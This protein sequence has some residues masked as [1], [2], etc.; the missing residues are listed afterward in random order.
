MSLPL[1]AAP[2]PPTLD[3]TAKPLRLQALA[4]ALAQALVRDRTPPS[5]AQALTPTP[6]EALAQA[7]VRDWTPPSAA[8]ALTPTPAVALAQA[9]V[10]DQIRPSAAQALTPTPAEALAQAL[11]AP[12]AARALAP[13][14]RGGR[15]VPWGAAWLLSDVAPACQPSSSVLKAGVSRGKPGRCIGNI[16]HNRERTQ[17]KRVGPLHHL[18]LGLRPWRRGATSANA[19]PGGAA[20][21]PAATHEAANRSRAGCAHRLQHGAQ[22]RQDGLKGRP[23]RRVGRPAPVHTLL[24]TLSDPYSPDP[25]P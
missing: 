1:E 25:C 10:R 5:A 4:Q 8:Q 7:L 18:A 11:T 23:R 16:R 19:Y 24:T 17:S 9:L 22:A 14:R 15:G 13:R 2:R 12:F 20:S 21:I 3:P 6:A